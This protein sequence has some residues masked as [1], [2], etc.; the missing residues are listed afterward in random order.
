[1]TDRTARKPRDGAEGMH[2]EQIVNAANQL[3]DP[4]Q[5]AAFLDAACQHDASLRAEVEEQLKRE[6]AARSSGGSSAVAASAMT[7]ASSPTADALGAMIGHYKLLEQIGEGGMGVVYM[8]DQQMPVRRRVALKII[9][10]GMDTRQVIARFEAERQA[11]ALMDHPN[12]ARVLDAGT[13]PTGGPYFVME[14][15]RGI[16]ITEYCDKNNL[17]VPER[18][19]LFIQVCHAVQHAHQKGIIHRD[20]KP[21]NVLVTLHD[22]KPVP[23]VIDFGV[24]KAT[25]QQLT[26][27][28]L[29]TNFSQMIGTPLYMSPEQAEMSG[30]DIDTRSDIYSLGVL[31]YELLT[32]TTPFDKQRLREAPYDE[33]RR[34]IREED[35]PRPSTRISTR[36]ATRTAIAPH[37]KIDPDRL[38]ELVRGDLDWIVMK[39]IEKDRTQRYDTA[40]ALARDVERYLHDQPVEACPPSAAYRFR[41]FAR[42]NRMALT[43]VVLVSAILVLG[44]VVSTW[45]AVRATRAER[46]AEMARAAEA[47]QRAIAE[48]ARAAEADQRAIAE[49]QRAQAEMQREQAELNLQKARATVDE[50]FT[51]VSESKL[52]DVPGLQPLRKD[53]LEAAL[54]FHQG[55]AVERASDPAMLADV[56]ASYLRVAVIYQTINR[57]DDTMAALDNAIEVADRLRREYPDARE[58]HRKLA[59]FWQGWRGTQTIVA[60]PRDPKAALKVLNRLF[61]TWQQFAK[62]NPA[63]PGFKSDLATVDFLRAL[64]SFGGGKRADGIAYFSNSHAILE[65]LVKEHP[66]APEY[67]VALAA[68]GAFLGG[69]LRA[70][71]N[72][73]EGET[74]LQQSL[75]LR[76]QLAAEFPRSPQYR[77]D[78]ALSLTLL[79]RRLLT[80]EPA[81]AEQAYR[82]AV[83]LDQQLMLEYPAAPIYRERLLAA[84]MP[85]E[86]LLVTV[87]KA[88]QAEEVHQQVSGIREKLSAEHPEE[89]T[90]RVAMGINYRHI[91]GLQRSSGRLPDAEQSLRKAIAAFERLPGDGPESGDRR[92]FLA[93]SFHLLGEILAQSG[94]WEQAAEAFTKSLEL[95]EDKIYSLALIR[96]RAGQ[97]DEYRKLCDEGLKRLT[98]DSKAGPVIDVSI[99]C[100]L[101]PN[102]LADYAP[103]LSLAEQAVSEQPDYRLFRSAHAH[104]LVRGGK[105]AEAVEQLE[106]L[107]GSGDAKSLE[108]PSNLL[109][110]AMAHHQLG[111]A[112]EA[113]KLF[114]EGADWIAKNGPE[115]L[116]EDAVLTEPM[117][118][119]SRLELQLLLREVES[120]FEKQPD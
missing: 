60:G 61:D 112:A 48:A 30:L 67:R 26:E 39:A 105:A 80:S 9:K 40:N 3:Q 52:L 44:T 53:L 32:G 43:S 37:R 54:R 73:Q 86:N 31:L 47:D 15:V 81:Q 119:N 51:L 62:E 38:R 45:Q 18:L 12:I 100:A 24:A 89:A 7:E 108:Q 11:L 106:Q 101:G 17:P 55:F 104:L 90:Y 1:M 27:K 35:P 19:T 42:R 76:E 99:C 102:G 64:L 118:W 22:G 114:R 57:S 95:G 75:T 111:K 71:G 59:G 2:R 70:T 66:A 117:A 34:I 23:K 83:E 36:G 41:K 77:E 56:A 78:L 109:F 50:Y 21:S 49:I 33:V 68:V 16:S 20:L 58:Q 6:S 96:L 115:K 82:R 63:V 74:I 72:A 107:T 4:A 94:Q 103:L 29:F 79:G 88:T 98:P 25:N 91:A 85:L 69:A 10:P 84:L 5:R 8:A 13:A 120:L 92:Y 28:T 65:T 46:R 110:L 87:G 113:E 116:P 93:E 14:L 97:F